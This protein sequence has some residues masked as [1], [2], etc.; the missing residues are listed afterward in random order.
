MSGDF[1]Q[2]LMETSHSAR[3]PM[4]DRS[5]IRVE[6]ADPTTCTPGVA[7]WFGATLVAA[8]YDLGRQGG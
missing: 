2:L 7:F 8:A 6:T 1:A 3:A 5:T 4:R